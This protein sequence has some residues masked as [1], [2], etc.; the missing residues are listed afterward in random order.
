[1]NQHTTSHA[2]HAGLKGSKK[3]AKINN[4]NFFI[5]LWFVLLVCLFSVNM[6]KI[7]DCCVLCVDEIDNYDN[8]ST[9]SNFTNMLCTYLV[10]H[11]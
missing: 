9:Y 5:Q 11:V 1:M 6:D 8:L 2:R 10:L 3:R 4:N 7:V